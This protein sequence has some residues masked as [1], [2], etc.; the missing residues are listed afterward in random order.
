MLPSIEKFPLA[1]EAD[2]RVARSVTLAE[3][4]GGTFWLVALLLMLFSFRDWFV[5]PVNWPQAFVIRV[6]AAVV[7]IASG[8]MQRLSGR[9]DWAPMIAR[10]RYTATVVDVAGAIAVLKDGYIVGP[11]GAG[12]GAGASAGGVD[13]VDSRAGSFRRHQFRDIHRA[14]H[15]CQPAARAGIRELQPPCVFARTAVDA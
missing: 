14:R 13:H 8:F 9:I 3:I 4:N 10:L 7:I 11:A 15:C 12:A 5:D 1:K 6:A 2:F